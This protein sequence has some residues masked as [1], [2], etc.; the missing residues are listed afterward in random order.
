MSR[1]RLK[2]I[3]VLSW[4]AVG[5]GVTTLGI[6]PMFATL[7]WKTLIVFA[8]FNFANLSLVYFF[9]QETNGRTL[10]EINLLFAA[11]S[12]LL[13]E[14]EKEFR[15]WLDEVDGNVATAERRMM[16][17]VNEISEVGSSADEE[18]HIEGKKDRS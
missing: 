14:N 11:E 13:S 15:R 8:S 10:K 4:Q 5:C 3:H 17:E 1:E 9:F 18:S 7:Q 6:P 12:P 2:V 16:D